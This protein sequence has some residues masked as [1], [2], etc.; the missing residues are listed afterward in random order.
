M[1]LSSGK[2][3]CFKLIYRFNICN[4]SLCSFVRY[5]KLIHLIIRLNCFSINLSH[6]GTVVRVCE[7]VVRVTMEVSGEWENLIMDTAHASGITCCWY[8]N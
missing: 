5:F 6:T 8:T 4:L 7:C 2:G 3:L 1:K